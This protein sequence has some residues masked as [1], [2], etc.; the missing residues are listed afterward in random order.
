ML[1][2]TLSC[3]FLLLPSIVLADKLEFVNGDVINGEFV[4]ATE[5]ATVFRSENFGEITV[6]QS[7]IKNLQLDKKINIVGDLGEPGANQENCSLSS[8][9]SSDATVKCG[10]QTYSVSPDKLSQELNAEDLDWS[11]PQ[12][13]AKGNLSVAGSIERGN[14]H[15]DEWDADLNYRIQKGRHRNR[16]LAEY[17]NDINTDGDTDENY[18]GGYNYDL[19]LTE[20]WFLNGNVSWEKD[21]SDNIDEEYR[22]G[23]GGGYQFWETSTHSLEIEFGYAYVTQDFIV[24][25]VTWGEE[26]TFDAMTWS[27]DWWLKPMDDIRLFHNHQLLQSLEQGSD[28]QLDTETGMRFFVTKTFYGEFKYEWDTKGEP[29][30]GNQKNDEK[31]TIGVGLEW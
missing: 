17:E 3:L 8:F 2:K 24:E 14:N 9:G 30:A 29:L 27:L 19:F 6:E 10:L 23:I 20:K 16:F 11:E 26:K 4:S 22:Y 12:W 5:E 25:D 18:Y 31:W 13:E 1:K 7:K 15:K 28:Y 21:D